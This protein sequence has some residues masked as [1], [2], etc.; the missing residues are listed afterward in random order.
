MRPLHRHSGVL[1]NRSPRHMFPQM[2]WNGCLGI[3]PAPGGPLGGS[4]L[5]GLQPRAPLNGQDRAATR[6]ATARGY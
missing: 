2:G 6:S 5:G 3:V 4:G 1:E